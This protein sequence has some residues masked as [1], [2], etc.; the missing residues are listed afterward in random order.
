MGRS[1]NRVATDMMG[2]ARH[3]HEGGNRPQWFYI[4]LIGLASVAILVGS[5]LPMWPH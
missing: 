3:K 4:G 2:Q 5:L 1:V